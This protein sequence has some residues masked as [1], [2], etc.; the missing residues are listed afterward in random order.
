[1]GAD[2]CDAPVMQKWMNYLTEDIPTDE[3]NIAAG[4]FWCNQ[5]AEDGVDCRCVPHTQG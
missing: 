2:G 1:M 3:D 5:Q 4:L